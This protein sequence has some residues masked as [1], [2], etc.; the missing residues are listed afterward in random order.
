MNSL[1]AILLSSVVAKLHFM[2]PNVA[3][4]LPPPNRY[5]Q[6]H[7]EPQAGGGQVQWLS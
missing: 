7:P 6:V 1:G 4:H 5:F 3:D 2:M